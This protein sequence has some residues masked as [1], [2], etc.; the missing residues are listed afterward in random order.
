MLVDA[1]TYC[2]EIQTLKM[3]LALHYD[4]VDQFWVVEG[5]HTFS[6]KFKGWTLENTFGQ[7]APW[8]DKIH[9]VPFKA[10]IDGLDFSIKDKSFNF[11]SPAWFIEN[12]QRNALSACLEGM[13]DKDMAIVSDLDELINPDVL[14]QLRDEHIDVARLTLMNHYYYM[15]CRAIGADKAWSFPLVV[16]AQWWRDNL[17]IS[18]FRPFGSVDRLI[19]DAGWHFSYLGGV[20][21]ISKKISSF[22]HT[23][24]DTPEIN[25]AERLARVIE[26]GEDCFDRAGHEFAFYPVGSYPMAIQYLMRK[27]RN[28]VRWTLY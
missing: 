8:S 6:G 19:H 12:A 25:N 27:N 21:A 28:F 3:R 9:F 22:S 13:S 17:D 16:S 20:E 4:F 18:S 1:F 10:P 24:L 14:R 2:G 23:E 26:N 15:N 7:L 5:D 11:S